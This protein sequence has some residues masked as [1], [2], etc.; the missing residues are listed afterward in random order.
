MGLTIV[1]GDIIGFRW[2]IPASKFRYLRSL[3]EKRR[4]LPGSPLKDTDCALWVT[5][6]GA[7]PK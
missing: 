3:T 1:F 4:R 2:H 7:G 6:E 5:P